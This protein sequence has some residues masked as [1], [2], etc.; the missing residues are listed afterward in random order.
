MENQLLSAEEMN[1]DTKGK[2]LTF[3]IDGQP[4]G[5]PISEVVQIIGIQEITEIPEYPV[6]AKGVIH[7]RGSM[8]PVIDF[9]L[10]LGKPET[11]YT[12]RTCIIVLSIGGLGFGLIVDEVD[13]VTAI[14]EAEIASPPNISAEADSYLTG[15][16]RLHEKTVLLIWAAKLF[17]NVPA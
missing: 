3:F 9:R 5:I 4:F 7:L 2:Y 17:E 16:A 15:V 6:Y 14:S 1:G 11:P 12:E 10:R 13:E 8:I